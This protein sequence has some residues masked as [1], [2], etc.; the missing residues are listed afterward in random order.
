MTTAHTPITPARLW[1]GNYVDPGTEQ[2]GELCRRVPMLSDP[3]RGAG[4][5]TPDHAIELL[6]EAR[7]LRRQIGEPPGC[8]AL[9]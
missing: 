5:L 7:L 6:I 3:N 4:F 8:K 9:R 2:R 1:I